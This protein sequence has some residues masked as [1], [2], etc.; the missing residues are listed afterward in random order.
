MRG[1]HRVGSRHRFLGLVDIVLIMRARE[2]P[3]VSDA[4]R[5]VRKR[6]AGI[7][8][9]RPLGVPHGLFVAAQLIE[10]TFA[11]CCITRVATASTAVTRTVC[12]PLPSRRGE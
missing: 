9:H 1:L 6:I 10:R 11:S 7:Q 5:G 4:Q 2:G 3:L 12:R 8:F